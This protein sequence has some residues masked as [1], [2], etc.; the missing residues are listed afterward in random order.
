MSVLSN[1]TIILQ[2]KEAQRE[3]DF[4]WMWTGIIEIQ[5]THEAPEY[6]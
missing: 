6:E 1:N 3:R 4:D 5:Y 2:I